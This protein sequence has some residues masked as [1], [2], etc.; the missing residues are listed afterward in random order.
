MGKEG[1]INERENEDGVAPGQTGTGGKRQRK[2]GE[3]TWGCPVCHSERDK[4]VVEIVLEEANAVAGWLQ[5]TGVASSD[6]T[7][8]M[9]PMLDIQMGLSM[10]KSG[11][12][13]D[14]IYMRKMQHPMRS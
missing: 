11:K 8:G 13:Q 1:R 4:E 9:V 10:G 14:M 12:S 7:N 5:F 2:L 3:R 6:N